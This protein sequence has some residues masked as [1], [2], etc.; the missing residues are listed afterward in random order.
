MPFHHYSRGGRCGAVSFLSPPLFLTC[1]VSHTLGVHLEP[2]T[3]PVFPH[4]P[5]QCVQDTDGAR[6]R[7][8]RGVPVAWMKHYDYSHSLEV[9]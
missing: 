7:V 2:V 3:L 5:E 4:Q 6:H 9:S 8:W 1:Q